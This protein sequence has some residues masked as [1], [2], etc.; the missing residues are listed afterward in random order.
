M[1]ATT[2]RDYTE[3]FEV[4]EEG[5]CQLKG[6][7]FD[8]PLS[9]ADS[10]D[11][12]TRCAGT[13]KKVEDAPKEIEIDDHKLGQ[14]QKQ[15]DFGKNTLG[16]QMY[17]N[18][19]PRAHRNKRDPQTPDANQKISK[20]CFDGQ[21]KVWR[22]ELHKYD[23]MLDKET[24]PSYD[25]FKYR[26]GDGKNDETNGRKPSVQTKKRGLDSTSLHKGGGQDNNRVQKPKLQEQ[27]KSGKVSTPSDGDGQ[28]AA[29]VCRTDPDAEESED[30]VLFMCL[31][32]QK[33]Q[34]VA[35]VNHEVV[36]DDDDIGDVAL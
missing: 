27:K 8:Q 20:R 12:R 13:K 2:R 30:N 16:Y 7:S 10:A 24:K 19:V 26:S 36:D 33:Q 1:A 34:T 17:V 35:E 22:R 11:N 9:A 25:Q 29:I 14:R 21:V 23:H 6:E 3:S 15:L 4:E 31:N 28:P 5:S 18:T 32:N